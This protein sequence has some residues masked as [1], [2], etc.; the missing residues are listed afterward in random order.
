MQPT[1]YSAERFPLDRYSQ[2]RRIKRPMS[3][4]LLNSLGQQVDEELHLGFLEMRYRRLYLARDWK[5]KR[6]NG[7]LILATAYPDVSPVLRDH[8]FSN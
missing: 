3:L 4:I 1:E 5:C 8:L 6:E 7:A 2:Q